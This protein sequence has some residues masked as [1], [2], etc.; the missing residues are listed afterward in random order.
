MPTATRARQMMRCDLSPF[1]PTIGKSDVG[2][3]ATAHSGSS[4]SRRAGS[5]SFV[6]RNTVQRACGTRSKAC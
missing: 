5:I 4:F 1:L 6:S 2:A 3:I